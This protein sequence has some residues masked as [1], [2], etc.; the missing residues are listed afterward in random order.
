MEAQ[1][2]VIDGE[3]LYQS[4]A[5]IRTVGYD[6]KSP[7]AHLLKYA[8]VVDLLKHAF[9]VPIKITRCL[10]SSNCSHRRIGWAE[11]IFQRTGSLNEIA[12]TI[13]ICFII[14]RVVD[15]GPFLER[16]CCDDSRPCTVVGELKH[17]P[18][19]IVAT[20]AHRLILIE[21]YLLFRAISVIR[22]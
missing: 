13:S 2:S 11:Q 4:A 10:T 18:P 17:K 7:R 1:E 14:K 9:T 12:S 15:V 21:R 5:K 3:K 22:D 8:V 19:C 20:V 16:Q 6:A